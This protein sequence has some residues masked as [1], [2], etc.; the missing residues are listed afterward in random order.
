[1]QTIVTFA[2]LQNKDDQAAVDLTSTFGLTL[3]DA[4]E[5]HNK[6]QTG[7][8]SPTF[9]YRRLRTDPKPG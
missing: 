3:D 2:A 7:L 5:L 9:R 8:N 1:M 6:I 4:T